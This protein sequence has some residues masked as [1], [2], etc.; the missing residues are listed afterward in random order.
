MQHSRCEWLD[1]DGTGGYASATVDSVLTRKYH[2]LLV[3]NLGA[4]AWGRHVLVTWINDALIHNGGAEQAVLAP[5]VATDSNRSPEVL[6]AVSFTADP[7]PTWRFESGP[8]MLE[9]KLAAIHLHDMVIITYRAE[10]AV[11][12]LRLKPMLS[13]RRNHILATQNDSFDAGLHHYENGFAIT[14]YE[15]MPAMHAVFN[16][17]ASIDVRADGTWFE[18]AYYAEEEARGY[19]CTEDLCMPA[20]ID[21]KIDPGESCCV[22][23]G[24]TKPHDPEQL[25]ERELER[26]RADRKH[27]VK[28]AGAQSP[29]ELKQLAA[30]LDHAAGSFLVNVPPDGRNTV[31]AG[32]H[33]F[34]DWG[35][36][37]MIALPGVAFCRGELERGLAVLDTFCAHDRDGR[38]PNFI[39][40]A[41]G[42]PAYN[43]VD[44]SLWL[45]WAVQQ[46]IKHGGEV[47]KLRSAVWPAL[48]SIIHHFAN[49][50]RDDAAMIADGRLRCGSPDTQLTWMDAAPGGK[51]VTPRWGFPIEVNALWY[52]AL[53]FAADLAERLEDTSYHSPC[54]SEGLAQVLRQ[55]Y[56]LENAGYIADNLNDAGVDRKLRPNQV[57]A[58]SL[59]HSAF[60]PEQG[61]SAIEVVRDHLLTPRGLRTLDPRDQD[62]HGQCVGA[63]ESRDAAYHQGTVW[64]WL[65]GGFG[66]AWLKTHPGSRE[67]REFLVRYLSDWMP[68]LDEA[69]LGSVSEIF[70]GDPPH[71]PRGCIAQ[72]WSVA[73]LLRLVRLVAGLI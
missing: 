33:W 25:W 46:Y 15:G 43:S 37:T 39:G 53:C 2:G 32:Y 27:T 36:D 16:G 49:G 63:V 44:G 42:E 69:G 7:V 52:N 38:I 34:E 41:G 60:S 8:L 70:D 12:R 4:P 56:W 73:E 59:P 26:R 17:A 65:L 22:A 21:L 13:Y 31:L 62:Y 5:G 61:R 54:C 50:T 55:T 19:P 20:S 71:T 64:P 68:H 30:A 66:E 14:P 29:P 1:V 18:D 40:P 24:I 57:F 10:G 23:I 35:R 9:R 45:F 72:A 58:V 47:E 48:R 11:A 67:G 28:R 6:K 51:P 3:S